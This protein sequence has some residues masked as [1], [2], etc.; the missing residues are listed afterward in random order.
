[1]QIPSTN[2]FRKFISFNWIIYFLFLNPFLGNG[3]IGGC[4]TDEVLRNQ[5]KKDPSMAQRMEEIERHTKLYTTNPQSLQRSVITIPVVVHVLYNLD[6]EKISDDQ[7]KHQMDVLNIHFRKKNRDTIDIPAAFRNLAADVELEFCLAKTKPN[8]MPTSGI[9]RRKTSKSR[10]TYMPIDVD[11]N[12]FS[13]GGLDVWDATKY[14]N[15]W[16]CNL[17]GTGLAGYGY[18][19]GGNRD[20]DGIVVDYRYFGIPRAYRDEKVT[21]H[22]VGHWLNLRH[23]WGNDYCGEDYVADTPNQSGPNNNCPYF[24]HITCGN[25]PNGDLFMNYMDYTD[26]ACVNMFSKGQKARMLSLF[27]IGGYR[28]EIATSQGCNY[29]PNASSCDG[30]FNISSQ[31]ISGTEALVSWNMKGLDRIYQ[32]L[33]KIDGEQNWMSIFTFDTSVV[34][35][36][37]V[38]KKNYL[39]Q[40]KTEC[41][42]DIKIETT[43]NYQQKD[44]LQIFPIPASTNLQFVLYD[45]LADTRVELKLLDIMGRE[46]FHTTNIINKNSNKID[47]DVRNIVNGMYLLV[48]NRGLGVEVKKVVVEH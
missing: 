31:R 3:Q 44:A 23:I 42:F 2:A 28:S 6:S 10:Y 18:Y 15:I 45:I 33:Y 27:N 32:V 4:G 37:L 38:A 25:S 1:M 34:L 22:E 20:Y 21:V 26:N 5:L 8:G 24:P 7:I 29:Q 19:P 9:E 46:V 43:I 39:I 36:N 40:L 16:V 17:D 11:L 14:L 30:N 41:Q 48:I 47:I 13:N 35:N 12:F